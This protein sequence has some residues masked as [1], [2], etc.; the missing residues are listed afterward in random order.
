MERDRVA[1]DHM[2]NLTPIHFLAVA[3]IIGVTGLSVGGVTAAINGSGLG[4]P[5]IQLVTA[6]MSALIGAVAGA[7]VP[8]TP[9]ETPAAPLW[10]DDLDVP[11]PEP[12]EA[13][14]V[15]GADGDPNTSGLIPG[16][17]QQG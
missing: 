8:R 14:E 11:A 4:E 10:A 15:M 6:V 17:W 1:D 7:S 12:V 16:Q 2:R 3:V 13:V 5:D 9:T